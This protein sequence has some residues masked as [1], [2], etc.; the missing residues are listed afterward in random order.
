MPSAVNVISDE[1]AH[2]TASHHVSRKMLGGRQ[3]RTHYSGG[4][5][6]DQD[7]HPNVMWILVG[8]DGG[9]GESHK[10]VTGRKAGIITLAGGGFESAFAAAFERP[11]PPRDLLHRHLH[12]GDIGQGLKRK[13]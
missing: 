3:T 5:C 1:P 12:Y 13:Q 11:L 7:F 4:V 9:H 6:V 8:E 10:G 2:G